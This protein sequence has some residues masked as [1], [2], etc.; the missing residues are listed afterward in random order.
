MF[1]ILVSFLL[2]GRTTQDALQ[3]N[4]SINENMSNDAIFAT[5]QNFVD[6]T[7]LLD[8]ASPVIRIENGGIHL[9]NAVKLFSTPTAEST[10]LI[11]S[12]S[13]SEGRSLDEN[14]DRETVL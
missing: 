12:N 7:P 5:N 9:H 6:H 3:I 14:T 10:P 2:D 4:T 8:N 13:S 1:L 11:R